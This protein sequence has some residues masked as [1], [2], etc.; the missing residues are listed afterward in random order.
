MPGHVRDR[1]PGHRA[2]AGEQFVEHEAERVDIAPNGRVLA[3][4]LFR[5][6]VR[7][8]A[9]DAGRGLH[10]PRERRNAEV[11]QPRAAT[12]IDHHVRGF[13]IAMQHAGFVRRGQSRA[14]LPRDLHGFVLRQPADA[15]QQRRQVLAVDELH[16][17]KVQAV[18]VA[19]V[20]HATDVGV[21]DLTPDADFRVK[22]RERLGVE[23][24]RF[25]QKLQRDR[26][27]EA[28]VIGLV[29]LAHPAFTEETD[30]AVAA[31]EDGAGH[32]AL[33]GTG[34]RCVGCVG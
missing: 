9:G 5:R 8:R 22:A 32:K 11:G 26:L 6:H 23:A 19:D 4:E 20:V 1:A 25:R 10:V 16:R 15:P 7:G 17:Q 34:R 13:E 29:D 14:N 27:F 30:D 12:A 24:D 18:D 33:A 28:Q 31:G 2:L 3:F 21:R